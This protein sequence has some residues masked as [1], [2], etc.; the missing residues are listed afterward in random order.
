VSRDDPA[1]MFRLPEHEKALIDQAIRESGLPD[2][3]W[4]R[5]MLL[6]A[7][8]HLAL[9]E[10]LRRAHAEGERTKPAKVAKQKSTRPPK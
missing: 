1:K 4:I 9:S 3:V 5:A 7:A 2:G 6:A 8:G 10:Q